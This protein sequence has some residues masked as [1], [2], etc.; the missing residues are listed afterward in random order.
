MKKIV[1]TKQ[2]NTKRANLP[3][4]EIVT[5]YRAGDSLVK[6]ADAYGS[7]ATT[8]RRVLDQQ[9]QERRPAHW[10]LPEITARP[11]RIGLADSLPKEQ[12]ISKYR[13]GM[14][15][16]DLAAEYSVSVSTIRNVMDARGEA[17]RSAQPQ[18][19]ISR[20]LSAD[21]ENAV[22]RRNQAGESLQSIADS[23]GISRTAVRNTLARHSVQPSGPSRDKRPDL[24]MD[25]IVKR[26]E[27][28]ES[29]K[30]LADEYGVSPATI[31]RRLQKVRKAL[32]GQDE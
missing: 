13:D 32:G 21:T 17:R 15:L 27:A 1:K 12:I 16:A 24:P 31:N 26:R 25:E 9:G 2:P 3:V 30:E 14:S 11:G 19:G 10:K 6:I 4:D 29:A 5:R 7:S 23:L 18:A 8:I 28:G 22:I 20:V